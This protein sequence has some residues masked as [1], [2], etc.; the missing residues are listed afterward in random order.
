[1]SDFDMDTGN[2]GSDGPWISW[3]AKGTSD[4]VIDARQFFLRDG[5]GK[6]LFNGFA[7]GVVMDITN[8]KTG[9]QHGE[10]IA[11]KAPD[12][13]WNDTVAK[14][15]AQPSQEHKKG[16]SIRCAI[17]GGKTATWEQAAVGAW[18]AFTTLVPALKAGP[19]DGSL[20][21]VRMIGHKTEKF[22]RGSTFTPILEVM[23][24]VARPD[25]LKE[26][27]VADTADDPAPAAQTY[28]APTPSATAK[29][30]IPD[31]AAF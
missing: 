30:A 1:M 10:G 19:G 4:G 18:N 29:A 27:F 12:W 13:T 15:K 24:W 17:G 25:C 3:S 5:D 8:M 21:L 22:A 6:S 14:F 26:G 2:S 7:T 16:F 28:T 11:G 20:P 9:W 23:K 31:A